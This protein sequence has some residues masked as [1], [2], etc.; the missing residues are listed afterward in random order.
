MKAMIDIQHN[1]EADPFWNPRS[2]N[3]IAV[4]VNDV[5]RCPDRLARSAPG[6]SNIKNR[7]S[8]KKHLTP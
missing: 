6:V 8:I 5:G 4:E 7:L 2:F 3:D 1:M